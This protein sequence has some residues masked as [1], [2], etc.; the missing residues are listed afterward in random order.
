MRTGTGDWGTGNERKAI[1][2]QALEIGKAEAKVRE[3]TEEKN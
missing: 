1:G 2:F 3:A